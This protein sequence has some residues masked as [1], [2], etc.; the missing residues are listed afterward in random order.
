[1]SKLVFYFLL[2]SLIKINI[3]NYVVFIIKS[4]KIGVIFLTSVFDQKY[5]YVVYTVKNVKVCVLHHT[6]V[7]RIQI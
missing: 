3:Y 5:N 7:L 1:M 4:V 2:Q 6:L